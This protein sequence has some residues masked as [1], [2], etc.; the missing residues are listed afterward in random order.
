MKLV[1]TSI[2]R[3][4]GVI[5][6]V[7]C[8]ILLGFISL[9]ELKVELFPKIDL[10]IAVIATSYQGAAPQEIEELISKPIESAVSTVEGMDTIQSVSS[11]GASLVLMMF[12]Y[13]RDID[14]ALIDVR[15]KVDQIS[16]MLPDGANDPMVMRLDPNATP[17]VIASLSGDNLEKLQDI[18]E[19]DIQPAIERAPGVAS[20][21][22]VGGKEREI[23]INLNQSMLKNYGLTG[24][25]VIAA[26]QAENRTISAGTVEQGNQDVQLRVV[27][28]YTSVSDIEN[29]LITLNNGDTVRVKDVA[30]VEDTFKEVSSI[31]RVDGKDTL[32]FTIMKQSD[33]NTVETAEEVKKV[34]EKLNEK[35][36]ERGL[37]VK[38]IMDT[39]VYIT[40]SIDSVL[41][42]MIVGGSL[43]AIILL[44]FLRSLKATLVI[45]VSMPISIISTFTLMYFTGETL[46]IISMGGLAL[47]IGMMVDSSIVI[48]EN[49][50]KKRSEGLSIKEAAYHG[51]SELGPAVIASTLTTAA[52]FVPV[53]FVEGLASQIFRPLALTVVFALTASLVAAMTLVPMLSTQ[54]MRNVQIS[55][56]ED[57]GQYFFNRVLNKI[58]NFYGNVL[59]KALRR[60]KTVIAIVTAAF[61]GSLALMPV[62]GMELMP[63]TDSGQVSITAQLQNGA[64][65]EETESIVEEINERLKNFEDII[66]VNYVS[67]GGTT[68]G[69]TAGSKNVASYM[70]ELVSSSE[71]DITTD[72][73]IAQLNDLV[74]DIPGAE[75][76]ISENNQGM[77]T[78]SPISLSISGDNLDVLTDLGQQVVWIL[79]DID[80]TLNVKSSV[81]DGSPELQV[82][83]NR[84]LASAFG[85][86]YQQIMNEINV[87]FNGQV[88]T[89]YKED[90]S[91]YDVTVALPDDKTET[92][93]DLETFV[94][95]NNAGEDIPLSAVAEIVPVQ[96][97]SQ[98][99]RNN[100]E[101]T[102]NVTSDVIGRDLG[103]VSKEIDAKL[104][105][106]HLPDGYEI[107]MG[108]EVETMMES[109]VQLALALVLGIFL[110]YMVM[111][112]Q[113]E[114]ITY[115]FIIMFS[116]PTMVIGVILGLLI[117]GLPLSLP[118]FIGLIMLAGIVVNNGILLVEYINIL[119]RNGM[120]RMEAIV[121]A[122]KSRMR[123]ILMTTLTTVLAM[124]P[125]ALAIGEGAE[126]QQPMAVVVVFG[127][128][129]STIFTLVFVPVMYVVIDNISEKVKNIF[130]KDDSD[131]TG[132]PKRRIFKRRKAKNKVVEKE[133]ET[134]GGKPELT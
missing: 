40:A 33:A 100:Q 7:I 115:P 8:A 109:F 134:I 35:Y 10:P 72:Q 121:E 37:E 59:E 53:V 12:D 125:L 43:A 50:Y 128:T 48:L 107:S 38:T 106:I 78:G 70:I 6:F 83:V 120:E 73:F 9:R 105:Q 20:A 14:D 108:G 60:R 64:K 85:L 86:S 124:I 92:V 88:A 99:T 30:D 118:G 47:G 68:N 54:F 61:V 129:S 71:R 126:N 25:Q 74:S 104:K 131:K 87:A 5:M 28:E 1:N 101:R 32:I 44:L 122:G 95:R 96:G 82:V 67:I 57:N 3:P 34:I 91:E 114:S 80:G 84:E 41:D 97:P 75:I 18:A 130:N 45:A 93:R 27:G 11:Q 23:R 39:S 62:V 46:N 19:S 119:R 17:V 98:I 63:A 112:V 102:I 123:P 31:S 24:S 15:E 13:G 117:S 2:K 56:D 52:V 29:T 69:I 81:E 22:I 16:G 133:L 89:R 26:L 58:K 77:S 51:A 116:M 94:V 110:V 113:F 42:N 55:V 76:T 66:K 127:L 111:A 65:L 49:I 90:G 132:K 79:E 21:T 103:T 36:T 4:V